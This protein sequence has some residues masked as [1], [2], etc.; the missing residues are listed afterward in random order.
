M[1]H[2]R[3]LQ[4]CVQYNTLDSKLPEYQAAHQNILRNAG[5]GLAA[6]TAS[7]AASNWIRVLKT[8]KQAHHSGAVTYAQV[9]PRYDIFPFQ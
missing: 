2:K 9:L 5:I 7:A 4:G 6:A 1:N 8:T 3:M